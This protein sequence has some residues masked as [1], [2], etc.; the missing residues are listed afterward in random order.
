[1]KKKIS[2]VIPI[3]NESESIFKLIDEIILVLRGLTFEILIVNDGSSDSFEKLFKQIKKKKV[4]IKCIKHKKNLGKSKAMLTG[5]IHAHYDLICIMDGD[6]QNPP[7]EVK[8]MLKIWDEQINKKFLIVCGNRKNRKDTL[9]KRYSSRIANAVRKR[10]LKDGCNDTACALKMF[11]KR[12]YI[13][14]PYFKNVHRFLPALFNAFNGNVINIPI[15]DRKRKYGTSKFNFNN[16]F[17]VGI[18]DLFRVWYLVKFKKENF[19]C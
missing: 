18:I 19:K 13:K 11:R 12:D 9:I 6:G 10:I 4:S 7:V 5:I 2:I 17:W 16:R 8:K 14:I 3:Y 1:M 15:N